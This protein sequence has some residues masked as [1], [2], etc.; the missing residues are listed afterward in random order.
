MRLPLFNLPLRISFMLACNT[1][2]AQAVDA[3]KGSGTRLWALGADGD[4]LAE[5][6]LPHELPDEVIQTLR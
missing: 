2:L 6:G 5:L 4:I 1:G 3:L